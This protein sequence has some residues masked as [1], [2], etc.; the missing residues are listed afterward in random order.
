MGVGELDVQDKQVSDHISC[1]YT[2]RHTMLSIII[3]SQKTC[4]LACFHHVCIWGNHPAGQISTLHKLQS[5]PEASGMLFLLISFFAPLL[6]ELSCCP[7]FEVTA[8]FQT[9]QSNNL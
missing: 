8:L 1:V 2:N 5:K 6:S 7:V 3:T 9:T 4:V